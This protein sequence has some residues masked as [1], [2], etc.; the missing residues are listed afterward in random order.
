M[1][2]NVI[3]C[4]YLFVV[5]FLLC[6]IVRTNILERLWPAMNQRFMLHCIQFYIPLYFYS[7]YSYTVKLDY[8]I[9]YLALILFQQCSLSILSK[10]YR[11]IRFQVTHTTKNC[12]K[13]SFFVSDNTI[14]PSL[15]Y[16][17]HS[18]YMSFTC[19]YIG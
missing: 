1:Y 9:S 2:C 19:H 17:K 15:C 14:N 10:I 13:W 7:Q 12:Q 4:K 11:H 8:Y 16:N 3:Y 6:Y 5:K 18:I